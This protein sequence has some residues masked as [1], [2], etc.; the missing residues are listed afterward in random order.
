MKINSQEIKSVLTDG[1][2]FVIEF[3]FNLYLKV[4]RVVLKLIMPLV[5][6]LVVERMESYGLKVNGNEDID[7]QV[8]NNELY[9]RS[10]LEGETGMYESFMDGHW[11]SRNLVGT[12]AQ[13]MSTRRTRDILH[14][15]SWTLNF[16]NLQRGK[17]VWAVGQKHYDI[18]ND[19]YEV[20]LGKHMQYTCGYW[21]KASEGDLDTAQFHKMELIA[22][23]LKLK[24]GMKVLDIGCGF[25]TLAHHLAAKYGV[26]VTGCSISKEQTKYGEE[27]CRRDDLMDLVTFVVRDYRDLAIPENIGKFD[28]ITSVGMVE[29]VGPHNYREFFQISSQLLKEDGIFLLHTIGNNH[30]QLPCVSIWLHRYIFPNGVI[31]YYTKICEGMEGFYIIEDWQNFSYDYAKTIQCWHRNFEAAWHSGLRKMYGDRFYKVWTVYLSLAEA[32]FLSRSFQLW[33][34]VL[35]KD[36]LKFGYPSKRLL[37]N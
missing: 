36:G 31:P 8:Y 21:E 17:R 3:V 11:T 4:A 37:Q 26:H 22:E 29:H 28:R 30:P 2:L 18:G 13:C 25:G 35:S 12:F 34:I 10:A 5:K 6:R 19:L 33:Q 16:F 15:L 27:L 9:I 23:K 7:P 14:P 32:A 20:M 1:A 24:P